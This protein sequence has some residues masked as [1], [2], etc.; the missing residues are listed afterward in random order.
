LCPEVGSCALQTGG[1]GGSMLETSRSSRTN[2]SRSRRIMSWFALA[3][4]VGCP[5]VLGSSSAASGQTAGDHLP[6]SFTGPITIG[7]ISEPLTAHPSEL[8]A[9]GYVEQEFFAHGTA[10]AYRATSMPTDGRWTVAPGKSATYNTRTIVRRPEDPAKFNGT[11]VVEWMNESAGESA[12]DFDY[13][14]PYLM[15]DGYAYVAVTV[16]ALGVDGG[17]PILGNAT[18]RQDKGLVGTDPARYGTL[19]HPGE[20]YDED[21]FAQIGQA[22]HASNQA[23]LGGLSPRHVIAVGESQS[24]YFLTTFADALQPVTHAFDGIF[25]HSRGGGGVQ[26]NGASI[27]S[28]KG[29]KKLL[30]RTD[31]SVPVFMF[32]TQTDVVYLDYAAARQPDTRRI[33]TWEVAGTAHADAFEIGPAESLLGC[34]GMINDGPQH[35]VVQAAFA[36]FDKWVNDGTPPPSPPPFRLASTHP[37]TL[38]L[39]AHGN[40]LGGV[41]TPAVDVPISTLSG[42][43]PRHSK[44]ICAILGKTTPFGSA[45][46]ASL[47]HSKSDFLAAYTTSLDKAIAR[48]YILSA[49]RGALLAQAEQ[50]QFQS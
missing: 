32:E 50:V 28:G 4:I 34:H 3:A 21:I 29:P 49:D 1:F 11:V 47:Y 48:G 26:L 39:D 10:T 12:P 22:L 6:A 17:T 35:E 46:L 43:G 2:T 14:N 37:P 20:A 45:T 15:S 30:I 41:R 7:H 38:A 18:G 25:I 19:H 9:N 42:A 16:Q 36:A 5:T 24:A 33:R 23:V 27:R 44:I 13:L 40:V 8:A 31:L